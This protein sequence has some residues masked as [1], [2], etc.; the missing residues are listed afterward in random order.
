MKNEKTAAAVYRGAIC[1]R[2]R[3]TVSHYTRK[4]PTWYSAYQAARN[5]AKR[6]GLRGDRYAVN[7]ETH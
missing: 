5:G 3:G 6:K 4:Y 1:D 2:L 7:V